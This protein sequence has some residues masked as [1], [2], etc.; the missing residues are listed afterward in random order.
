MGSMGD[1]CVSVDV[2]KQHLNV[3]GTDQDDLIA[4]YLENA[5]G[6]V[7]GRLE[8]ST[9]D[10]VVLGVFA[11]WDEDST[12]REIRAAVMKQCAELHRFRGDDQYSPVDAY[13]RLSPQIESLIASW[14]ERTFA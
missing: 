9:T 10:S 3:I 11:G 5:H 2:I 7:M 12:P 14:L 4:V 13:G 1:P 8:R 6:I